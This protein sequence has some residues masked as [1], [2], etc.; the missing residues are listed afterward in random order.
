MALRLGEYRFPL[1]GEMGKVEKNL[2][3]LLPD[4]NSINKANIHQ[5]S[6]LSSS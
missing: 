2:P 5:L 1:G 6:D 3:N 4:F